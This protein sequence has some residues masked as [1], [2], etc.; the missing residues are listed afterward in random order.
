MPGWNEDDFLKEL[1]ALEDGMCD[2]SVLEL[3]DEIATCGWIRKLQDDRKRLLVE[4]EA[5]RILAEAL[6]QG[7]EALIGGGGD[8]RWELVCEPLADYRREVPR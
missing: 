5:L 2:Y 8:Q 1:R 7:I 6:A 4:L 3:L